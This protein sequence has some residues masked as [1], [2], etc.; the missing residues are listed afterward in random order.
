MQRVGVR[1]SACFVI[2][3]G[4]DDGFTT[5]LPLAD[6]SAED[7]LLAWQ[8]DG[9]AIS[10]DH[11]GP[12]RLIVPKLYAWKSAKWICGLEFSVV[13]RPGYWEQA[14]YHDHGDPWLQERHGDRW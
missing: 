9:E 7:V 14:G 12:V 5:N 6:F 1:P 4:Y 3:H 8:H 10:A 11:G 2:A 13:D